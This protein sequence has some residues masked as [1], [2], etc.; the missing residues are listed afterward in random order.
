[1]DYVNHALLPILIFHASFKCLKNSQNS[2]FTLL[3]Y[4]HVREFSNWNGRDDITS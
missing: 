4:K 1:M 2:L 3:T